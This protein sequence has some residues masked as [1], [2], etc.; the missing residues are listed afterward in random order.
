MTFGIIGNIDKPATKEVAA[1]LLDYLK[2]KRAPFVVHESLAKLLGVSDSA[3]AEQD[4]PG[5]CTMLIALGG[6]GTM[7]ST[8]RI[9]GQRG[10][11]ILGVNLGKLG[12][13]AEV[14]VEELQSCIDD[15]LAGR[16]D[17]EDRLVLVATCDKNTKQ[18]PALNEV[19]IDKGAS[20][21]VMEF[22]TSVNDD[23]LVTYAAD[24]I[25][26]N[27]PTGSTAYSLSTGGPIVAPQAKVITINPIAPH[28]LTARPVIVQDESIIRVKVSSALKPV[29]INTDG[30]VEDFFDAPVEF[31]I[32]KAP[33][34]V[35]LVKRKHR[36]FF[37]LL[38]TK[39]MWGKDVRTGKS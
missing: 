33:Y 1:N 37:E 8:A 39:L 29:H 7:L 4:L 3:V 5:K 19:V 2:K 9:I 35:K 11:P 15:I 16:F 30:Q 17:V 32:R 31:T 13:L 26:L 24:G 14:S 18:Y 23:F 22:E 28:T 38:R 10:I 25:I 27:T 6:D 21:R 36:K 20:T 34:T 12:F